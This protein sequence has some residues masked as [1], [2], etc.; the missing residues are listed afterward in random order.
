M[1]LQ[2][3]STDRGWELLPL[4][5]DDGEGPALPGS[6]QYIAHLEVIHKGGYVGLRSAA[7]GG[8]FL[9]A[10]RRAPHRLCF[11]SP[12]LG[13]WEQFQ[14][15]DASTRLGAQ[16]DGVIGLRPR[17]LP[18]FT[19]TVAIVPAPAER[20]DE[21]HAAAATLANGLQHWPALPA[22]GVL[23]LTMRL[24][25]GFAHRLLHPPGPLPAAFAA[26]AHLAA[27]RR[28]S[29]GRALLAASRW[30]RRRLRLALLAWQVGARM[31]RRRRALQAQRRQLHWDM[32]RRAVDFRALTVQQWCSRAATAAPMTRRRQWRALAWPFRA[33]AALVD[34]EAHGSWEQ[35]LFLAA[36][37]WHWQRTTALAAWRAASNARQLHRMLA[38]RHL[39][40]A[41]AF[42]GWAAAARSAAGH[43][44]GASFA[45]LQS[46]AEAAIATA[47]GLAAEVDDLERRW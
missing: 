8:R 10:R 25:A 33:W 18:R 40:L 9:Q 35:Q 20:G 3:V 24:T 19:W 31:N 16:P 15:V 14:V 23:D 2:A 37:F 4:A 45:G 47:A 1:G 27:R 38:T 6:L 42:Q 44:G 21:E 36:A 32:L 46:A 12:R 29:M 34:A 11:F 22:D 7:A 39:L 41:R 17:Q 28:A 5:S 30:Q 13:V 26:W 43:A